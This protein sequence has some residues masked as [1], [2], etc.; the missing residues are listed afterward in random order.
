[1]RGGVGAGGIGINV[2]VKTGFVLGTFKNGWET[3]YRQTNVNVAFV[4]IAKEL[5]AAA[6]PTPPKSKGGA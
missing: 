4:K 2:N 3:S 5:L 6:L 1:M